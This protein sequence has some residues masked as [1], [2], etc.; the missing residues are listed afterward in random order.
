MEQRH[1]HKCGSTRSRQRPTLAQLEP[2]FLRANSTLCV[3][4]PSFWV[5]IL[6]EANLE[7]WK[8]LKYKLVVAIEDTTSRKYSRIAVKESR[9]SLARILA[10]ASLSEFSPPGRFWEFKE[11]F[12]PE[13][14]A[15]EQGGVPFSWSSQR[16]NLGQSLKCILTCPLNSIYPQSPR[17]WWF[18]LFLKKLTLRIAMRN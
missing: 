13:Q 1:R 7:T 15:A 4:L 11:S 2:L 9:T 18:L 12:N 5:S 17:K 10:A 6:Y 16:D 3:F 14:C 8:D